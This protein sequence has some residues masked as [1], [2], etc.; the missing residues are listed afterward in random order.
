MKKSFRIMS[1]ALSLV[2][3]LSLFSMMAFPASADSIDGQNIDDLEE[4]L[5]VADQ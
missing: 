3:M 1:L 5:A 2:L 4:F